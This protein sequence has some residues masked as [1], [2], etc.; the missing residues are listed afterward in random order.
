MSVNLTQKIGSVLGRIPGL[1]LDARIQ[2]WSCGIQQ[3]CPH[4]SE[5]QTKKNDGLGVVM[6]VVGVGQA[7][8]I[9]LQ[10]EQCQKWFRGFKP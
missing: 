8:L 4:C 7:E 10:C 5:V 9:G 3:V 2:E 1:L 6:G